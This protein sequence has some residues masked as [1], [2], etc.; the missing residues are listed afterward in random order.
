MERPQS[1]GAITDLSS[2]EIRALVSVL[3]EVAT[4][5]DSISARIDKL[6]A[7]HPTDPRY[8]HY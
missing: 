4:K 6:L 1:I 5:L 2:E 3:W 8:K 7:P